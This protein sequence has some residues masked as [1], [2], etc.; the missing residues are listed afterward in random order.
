MQT[1]TISP[2]THLAIAARYDLAAFGFPLVSPKAGSY[3]G[4]VSFIR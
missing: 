2:I 4:R 3:I 1:A